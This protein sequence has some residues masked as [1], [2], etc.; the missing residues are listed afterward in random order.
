[1][2]TWKPD[3]CE[4]VVEEIYNGN[5]IVG[6]GQ[7]IKKCLAHTAVADQDLYGVLYANP[8]GENK[9]KN[10]VHRLLLG[11]D[12]IKNLGLEQ[13]ITNPDG[14]QTV[15]F[16][17]GISFNWSFNGVGADRVLTVNVTGVTLTN[18]QKN[19]IRTF[20]NNKFGIGKVEII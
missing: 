10:Q 16:K 11:H 8:D 3:T 14:T 12:S 13:T 7:V 9:R 1:M 20:V 4:C 15:E 2:K 5:E 17:N 18:T 19:A 6:G